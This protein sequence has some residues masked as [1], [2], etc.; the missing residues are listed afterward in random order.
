[1]YEKIWGVSAE[2]I[3]GMHMADVIGRPMFERRAKPNL[4]QCFAGEESSYEEWFDTAV[5]RKYYVVTYS[6]LQLDSER[7]DNALV[8]ARDLTEHMLASERLRDAQIELA[9]VNRVATIGQLTTS[10]SHEV[11]QPIG[12]M[13]INAHAAL[14]MLTAEPPDLS[15]ACEALGDII[16]DGRRVSDIIDRVRALVRK[17]PLQ[18]DLLDIN[19]AVME[20]IAL[21]RG[22]ILRSDVLLD[23]QLAGNLPPIRGD[24]VQLQQVIMNRRP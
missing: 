3:I 23:I 22:E 9:H 16:K 13:V 1:M 12:A 7:V 18:T 10:I 6:P 8:I 20:T 5:G 4:D 2:R 15:K 24:R 11:N 19:E 21:T 14:R 17:T